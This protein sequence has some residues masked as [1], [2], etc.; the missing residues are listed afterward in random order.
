M[1]KIAMPETLSRR[2]V[3]KDLVRAWFD[4]ALNPLIRA[5]RS[6]AELLRQRDF[7]WRTSDNR[8]ASLVPVRE[9][10]MFDVHDNLDQFL[11]F[12]PEI[13]DLIVAHDQ[14]LSTLRERVVAYASLLRSLPA[15]EEL[16]ARVIATE[17]GQ[18]PR[19]DSNE[20]AGYWTEYLVNSLPKLPAYYSTAELWNAH[21]AEVF[22]IRERDEVRPFWVGVEAA[23][24]EFSTAVDELID[25]LTAVRSQLSLDKGVPIVTSI[26]S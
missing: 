14:K 22:K 5:L 1:L 11:S 21:S 8:F 24:V 3:K 4:T 17:N 23:R 19:T 10:L 26:A 15:F 20:I 2:R 13:K 7:T 9:H 25:A 12:F 18:A 16:L 6:E